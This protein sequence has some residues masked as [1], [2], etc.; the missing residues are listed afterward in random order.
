M[1]ENPLH[2]DSADTY[3]MVS[4]VIQFIVFAIIIIQITIKI[5]RL[6]RP[7]EGFIVT[8]SSNIKVK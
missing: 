4:N 7:P 3:A 5:A 1:K 8:K 2:I 6:I